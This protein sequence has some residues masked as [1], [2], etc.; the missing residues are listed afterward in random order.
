[1]YPDLLK[2][3]PF[4]KVEDTPD[5]RAVATGIA[6]S[7]AVDCDGESASF[8]ETRKAYEDW[9][10]AAYNATT[11]AHQEPSYGNLRIQHGLEIAGKVIKIDYRPDQKQIWISGEAADDHVSGLLRRG[12]LTGASHAGRY[13]RRWHAD[14]GTDVETGRYC[15]TCRKEVVVSYWPI[16]SEISWV[17]KPANPS[18]PIPTR[19][20]P[21]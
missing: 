16:L 20:F 19:G 2:I 17:D 15:P 14:C 21:T 10:Q 5:G 11:S 8:P 12:I 7:D 4:L 9:S 6:T 3:R 18:P 1:M 13:G